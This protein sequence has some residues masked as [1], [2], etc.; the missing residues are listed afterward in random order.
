M[1]MNTDLIAQ[2]VECA[3]CSGTIRKG[4]SSTRMSYG[5]CRNCLGY[6]F[7]QPIEDLA[8][9]DD[10]TANLLPF[11]FIRLDPEGRIVAYNEQESALSGLSRADVLAK[12]FFRTVAPC[13]CVDEFEGTLRKL[14]A[15]QKP[16]RAQIEF[17]FKFKHATTMVSIAIITD[18]ASGYATLL[19]R[20]A[21][22]DVASR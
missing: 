16:E 18:A 21:G 4:N 1:F 19:I 8:S 10:K 6:Q 7:S 9:L 15:S 11:G 2:S 17:L 5:I 3:W 12:S 22:E 20:K 14:M 13:T